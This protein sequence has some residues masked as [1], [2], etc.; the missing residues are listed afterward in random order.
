MKNQLKALGDK[1]ELMNNRFESIEQELK[2]SKEE[3]NYQGPARINMFK[4]RFRTNEKI[5]FTF[6]TNGAK[7]ESSAWIG[8]VPASISHGSERNND[9]HDKSF[10]YLSGKTTATFDLPNPGRGS[11][12]VRLHD[13]D[14][15]GK[16]LA[17]AFFTV[18]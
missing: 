6:K 5:F 11:W 13:T 2:L 8:I 3:S 10:K 15:N 18:Y 12:T 16:E 1:F 9:S 7:V 14:S 4:R 17:Y